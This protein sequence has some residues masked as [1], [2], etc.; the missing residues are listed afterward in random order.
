MKKNT[1]I[2]FLLIITV[3]IFSLGCSSKTEKVA[4]AK[5]VRRYSAET[6]IRDYRNNE[7]AADQKYKDKIFEVTGLVDAVAK[8]GSNYEVTI[9]KDGNSVISSVACEFSDPKGV[10]SLRQGEYV[11]IRGIG[12]G[13]S[14][15]PQ[16]EYC[17]LI[18]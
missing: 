7:A 2:S 5:D 11:T 15:L 18:K 10:S 17:I 16:L 9:S 12:N 8:R 6:L 3:C 4:N 14:I 13:K 1:I